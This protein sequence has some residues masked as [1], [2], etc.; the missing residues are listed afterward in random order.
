MADPETKP[1]PFPPPVEPD[2]AD[3]EEPQSTLPEEVAE[4]E[5]QQ[6]IKEIEEEV[7]EERPSKPPRPPPHPIAEGPRKS[8][9]DK[10][11]E[12]QYKIE[13]RLKAI[14]SGRYSRVIKM[15]RKPQHEEFV[16]ASKI[17]GLGIALV[18][19]IGFGILLFMQWFMA[20]LRIR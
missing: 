11:W 7:D 10:A 19:T 6:A 4:R 18:G 8:F 5:A 13:A 15:A 9:L 3:E 12:Q 14:G 2:E 20:V 16:K 1:A 17:T